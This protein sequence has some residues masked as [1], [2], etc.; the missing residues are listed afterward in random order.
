MQEIKLQQ[1]QKIK[2]LVVDM[3]KNLM[4]NKYVSK[5]NSDLDARFGCKGKKNFWL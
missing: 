3:V 2:Q 1:I 4:I 5:Y